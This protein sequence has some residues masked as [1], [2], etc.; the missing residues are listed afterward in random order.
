MT[1]NSLELTWIGKE[2]R[3]RPEPRILLEDGAASY[4]AHRRVTPN[5]IFDNM[6]IQG[7]NL[8]ALKAL[9]GDFTGAFRCIFIDP[10]YNTGSAFPQYDDGLEH[11]LWL[12]LIR[13]RLEILHTLLSDDGSLWVS[14]DDNESHYLKVLC[15]EI[16]GRANFVANVVWQKK[17]SPQPNARWLSDSHDHILVYA[18]Y[19]ERWRP[20]KL[21]RD[22]KHNAIYKHSD[23]YDGIDKHGCEYGRGPWFPGD[24]TASLTSGQ[25]GKQYK[26]TGVSSNLYTI[27][28]PSGKT[29]TPP[30]GTCW[31]YSKASFAELVADNRISFGK[32]GSNRPCVK[33]FR[34]EMETVGITPMTVWHYEDVGENRVAKEEVKAFNRDDPF[35]TPKPERLMQRIIHLAT[36]PGDM[37]LDSFAGSGTTGAVAHKLG[38]RWVMV[39]LG[40]QCATH[41]VPRLK[42]VIDGTDPNGI[43]S[44]AGWK[45]GG[46]F[47]F[48]TL[49]P[50]LLEKDSWG[51][52]VVSAGYNAPMLAEA[53]CK[54]EGFTYGPDATVF[55][56][57]GHS[58]ET[59]FIYVTDQSLT[60][61]QLRHLSE[62][63][64][65]HRTLLVCCRA[66]RG[67]TE[68]FPNLTMKKIPQAVLGRC[69][70]GCDDYSL[71]VRSLPTPVVHEQDTA[72]ATPSPSRQRKV[73]APNKRP[74]QELPLF[75][76]S[77]QQE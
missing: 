49:A 48:Y 39:E 51:N 52:W 16:F 32:S 64:G 15:D 36:N 62:E 44:A 74:V 71:N 56:S 3:A 47:R 73:R 5:D 76:S 28:T 18:K 55:W 30:P 9:E 40:S 50:S 72:T 11:S 69:E 22:E 2:R 77:Q 60:K 43:S 41:I 26:A 24:T 19:K 58:T 23:E 59:D 38:R 4:H 75:P 66:W 34:R 57:H 33:R 46:G 29:I 61:P 21:P 42:S 68:E 13:D 12:S 45:G 10:P 70:W 54:L 35:A 1:P 7:D 67:A 63:V 20:N 14:I 37:V 6:L 27:T 25:R 31:R 65:Q 8:L 17:S 53:V